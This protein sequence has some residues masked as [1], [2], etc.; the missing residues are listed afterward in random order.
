[1]VSTVPALAS[2]AD[3]IEFRGRPGSAR[4]CVSG[5][6]VTVIS[7]GQL[8]RDGLTVAEIGGEYPA[9]HPEQ[10]HAAIAFYIYN[11][12]AIDEQV[13]ADARD[14]DLAAETQQRARRAGDRTLG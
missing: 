7:I 13:E 1:M 8:W 10:I 2:I 5:T 9:L 14:H 3:L 4:A 6:G 11:R 12:Q